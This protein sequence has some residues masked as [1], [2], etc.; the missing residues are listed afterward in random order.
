MSTDSNG[1]F[2]WESFFFTLAAT[3]QSWLGHLSLVD[4]KNPPP[5]T[6]AQPLQFVRKWLDWI[7]CDGNIS[8]AYR[9]TTHFV[10]VHDVIGHFC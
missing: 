6:D 3:N 8:L 2:T 7:P 10:L 9:S 4:W 1:F 5:E